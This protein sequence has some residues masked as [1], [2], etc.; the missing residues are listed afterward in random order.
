VAGVTQNTAAAHRTKIQR[1][2]DLSDRPAF[3]TSVGRWLLSSG[4]SAAHFLALLLVSP[5]SRSAAWGIYRHWGR[6]AFRIFHITASLRDDNNGDLG[7]KPHL[8]VWLNQSSLTDTVALAQVLPPF[9][10]IGNIEY[11]AMPFLGW[12]IVPLRFVVIVRQ[13]REQAIRGIDRACQRLASGETWLISTEGSRTPNGE[14]LPFKKG[15]AV[16]AIKAQ[17]TIIPLAIHGARVVMPTGE[18]RIRPGHIEIHLLHALATKGLTYDDRDVLLE[19]LRRLAQLELGATT[20]PH[21][22]D[23]GIE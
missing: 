9:Y 2:M 10:A 1:T 21:A 20:S 11:A 22:R 18:W 5:F 6:T 3:W 12:A 4:N 16:L 17:A 15:P 8:Y 19:K 7:P 14:L 23:R 13:W